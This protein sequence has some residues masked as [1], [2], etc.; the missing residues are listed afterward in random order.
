MN[1]ILV[2][3]STGFIGKSLVNNL[4]KDKRKVFAIIRKSN[5]NI[6]SASKIKKKQKNFFPIFFNKNQELSKKISNL[7]P[8]VVVNLAVYYMNRDP[9]HSDIPLIIN[10][11]VLFPTMILD[12]CCKSKASKIINICSVMQ[13]D[14]NKIDN[15]LN[16]YALTKILFSLK[17]FTTDFA[18]ISAQKINIPSNLKFIFLNKRITL[19]FTNFW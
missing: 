12:L 16:F 1:K 8:Q 18:T 4:L 19:F 11:N 14:K 15:P 13:C 17:I 7:N 2:T 6:K 9:D 5:K 3:G 10:S